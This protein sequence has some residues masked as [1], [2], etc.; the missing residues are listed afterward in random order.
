[1][2]TKAAPKKAAPKQ[3]GKG[4]ASK[5]TGTTSATSEAIAALTP[6]LVNA[7]WDQNVNAVRSLLEQGANVNAFDGRQGQFDGHVPLHV[8]CTTGNLDVRSKT[9]MLAVLRVLLDAGAQV[10]VLSNPTHRRETPL[11]VAVRNR[12][13]GAVRMLLEAGADVAIRDICVSADGIAFAE[14][15]VLHAVGHSTFD[16]RAGKDED[17]TVITRLLLDHGADL[18]AGTSSDSWTPGR[19]PLFDA[20]ISPHRMRMLLDAGANPNAAWELRPL[21]ARITP[22]LESAIKGCDGCMRLLID[23][24][25]D[26]NPPGNAYTPLHAITDTDHGPDAAMAGIKLL[27]DAGA[28]ANARDEKGRTPYQ[29]ALE[30]EHSDKVLGLLLTAQ[31]AAVRKTL[32]DAVESVRAEGATEGGEQGVVRRSRKSLSDPTSY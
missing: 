13:V 18:N 22:L 32:T 28:D 6:L 8:A 10:N 29:I 23:A 12:D 30:W 7:V 19:T 20:A 4:K 21:G 16:R 11:M 15:S 26:V 24:G 27:L 5:A 1:M 2:A 25:A 31:Q 9:N 3:A 17:A 14:D